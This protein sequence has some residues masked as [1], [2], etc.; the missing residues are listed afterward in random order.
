MAREFQIRVGETEDLDCLAI[1]PPPSEKVVRELHD[2]MKLAKIAIVE[3]GKK[4]TVSP[5]FEMRYQKRDER[6]VVALGQFAASAV[7]IGGNQ[8]DFN[9]EILGLSD[10]KE[11]FSQ[12]ISERPDDLS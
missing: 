1:S 7:Q 12:E 4:G 11:L 5:Y 3:E 8:I 6:D 10:G 2:I 9:S